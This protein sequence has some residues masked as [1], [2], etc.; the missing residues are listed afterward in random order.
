M[1]KLDHRQLV[2]ILKLI[3][4]KN[5]LPSSPHLILFADS[6]QRTNSLT[7]GAPI[8]GNIVGKVRRER[9]QKA[10]TN[11]RSSSSSMNS[12][13]GSSAPPKSFPLVLPQETIELELG[14]IATTSTAG[15]PSTADKGV[16]DSAE[17]DKMLSAAMK[18]RIRSRANRT[19][20]QSESFSNSS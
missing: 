17:V 20:T 7:V 8:C 4:N 14:V 3:N 19:V 10:W 13:E 5:V 11:S 2:G 18:W 12:G 15:K 1:Q 16:Y 9:R 6:Y